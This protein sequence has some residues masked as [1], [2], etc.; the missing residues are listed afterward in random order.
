M[1]I[2]GVGLLVSSS[3]QAYLVTLVLGVQGQ[4][5]SPIDAARGP[6]THYGQHTDKERRFC[7]AKGYSPPLKSL[8]AAAA[9][10]SNLL[11]VTP[12]IGQPL[13]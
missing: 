13:R 4:V 5:M 8:R 10:C 12:H 3:V 7:I 6:G 9:H 11:F 2:Q 1:H